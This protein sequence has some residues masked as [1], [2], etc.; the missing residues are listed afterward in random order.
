MSS[1]S[2]SHFNR[3]LKRAY[4]LYTL[5]FAAFVLTLAWLERAGL[6]RVWIGYAFILS[7]IALYAVIGVLCR[8]TDPAEYYVAGRR[9]PAMFNGMATAADWISAA[10]FIGLAG[11]LYLSGFDGLAYVMGWTGGYCLVAFFI[12]PYL[13]KFGRFTIPDF[14]AARYGGVEV[15]MVAIFAVILCSFVYVVAQVYGVGLIITR[16]TGVSFEIGIFIGLSGMLVCSFLGGMKAVTWTQ[17]AQYIILIIAYLT[18][19][20]LL[21][22]KHSGVPLPQLVYGSTLQSVAEREQVIFD[23][24]GE[25]AVRQIFSERATA[26]REKID[27]LPGSLDQERARARKTLE[28]LRN[29]NAPPKQIQQAEKALRDMPKDPDSARVIWGSELAAGARAEPPVAHSAIFAGKD[30][31][32]SEVARRNFMALLFCLML[33]T[34]GLPHILTR[35]YTTTSVQETRRSV[36]WSLFFIFLLYCTAPAVAVFVKYEIY[37]HLVGSEFAKLPAWVAQWARIDGGSL[38]SVTDVN[39]DGIVQ[40]AEVVIHPDIIMLAMPEI[41]GLPYIITG[42]VAAGG[43]AAALSTADSLLLTIANALS[44][45]FYYGMVNPRVSTANRVAISKMALMLV[46][47]AAAIAASQRPGNILFMVS[48]AFSLAASGLFP[49]LLLGIFWKRTSR[50][51]AF[52]GMVAGLGVCFYYMVITHPWLRDFFFVKGPVTLWW[53][54]QPISA[55]VFGVP[56]GFAVII[57]ASLLSPGAD[58]KTAALVDSIRYPDGDDKIT[59]RRDG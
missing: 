11:T 25:R 51:A 58:A 28:D 21:S 20:V 23:D 47:S 39:K 57:T 55:G 15:R 26:T 32:A 29:A 41:A 59:A 49:A 35:Y 2:Q 8:T 1:A 36:F 4:L 18:P 50:V 52:L 42:L 46:A 40:L 19:V 13:R 10:S 7:T 17:V 56:A 3:R 14:F 38:L 48:A 54:I 5:G 37:H 31:Q 30:G 6:P 24:P 16:L 44:H 33:G 9:V 34:A 53:D 43:L 45:D 22:V 12:A 27:A